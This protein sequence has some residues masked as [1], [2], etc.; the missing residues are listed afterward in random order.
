MDYRKSV[1]A[2]TRGRDA[3]MFK[4]IHDEI[5]RTNGGG[6]GVS[7]E[8]EV[9]GC[10]KFGGFKGRKKVEKKKTRTRTTTKRMM[11]KKKK[12]GKNRGFD[13]G[14]DLVAD[15]DEVVCLVSDS[16]DEKKTGSVQVEGSCSGGKLLSS[17][18]EIVVL[19]G[20]EESKSEPEEIT[21]IVDSE[22]ENNEEEEEDVGSDEDYDEEK[23]DSSFESSGEED[24]ESEKEESQED[25]GEKTEEVKL[26]SKMEDEKLSLDDSEIEVI[27]VE[28]TDVLSGEEE[29]VKA[30]LKRRRSSVTASVSN[31]TRSHCNTKKS[32]KLGAT[33]STSDEEEED[34]D[35]EDSGE[36]VGDDETSGPSLKT[37]K[38]KSG[39]QAHGISRRQ[40]AKK[41]AN[42][43]D[44]DDVVKILGNSLFDEDKVLSE[45]ECDIS[46]G[47]EL[48][49]LWDEMALSLCQ[50][51]AAEEESKVDVSPV[52]E[53][54]TYAL[55]Q[56]G[57]HQ[58]ILNEEIGIICKFCSYVDVEIKYYTAPFGKNPSRYSERRD[59]YGENFDLDDKLHDQDYCDVYDSFTPAQGTVWEIIPGIER[60]LHQHQRDGFEFIWKKVAG[61]IHLNKL[62]EPTDLDGESG[63]IISHA[64]GTG[65]TRLAIVFL[66]SYMKL[67]PNCRPVIIAPCS[68]LLSWEAEFKK[69]KVDIPFHNLNQTRFSGKENAAAMK[70]IKP[71]Q[72]SVNSIRMVKLYSWKKYKSVLGISY[73][74]FEELVGEDTKRS[75]ARNKSNGDVR[76]ALLELPGLLFLDEGHTPRNDQSLIFKALSNVRTDKRI[77]LSG[78]PFQN[79]FDE[80]YNTLL[81]VRPK[82]ADRLT[83]NSASLA[84]KKG[85]EK[86]N[87]AKKTWTSLTSSIVKDG[88]NTLKVEMLDEV[89]RTIDSFVHVH[90]GNIL[91]ERLP[92]LRDSVVVLQPVSL[93]KRLLDK[94]QAEGHPQTFRLEYCLSVT[95]VHPALMPNNSLDEKQILDPDIG[96]KT[97]FLMELI[98]L[99]EA[100]G[101]K[102][103]VFSQ[104]LAPLK[105]IGKQL[106]SRFKWTAGKEVLHM[107]GAVDADQR[108]SLIK[109]FNDRRSDA[110]VLLASTKACSEGI[111]LVGA[112]RVVLLDVVW[113]PS[114]E[115]QAISRAYRL[116]QQKVVYVY[117]LIAS[118][119]TEEDKYCRQARKER[120]SEL[121]FYSSDSAHSSQKISSGISYEK[122]DKL[123]EEIIRRN[124]LKDELKKIIYQPKESFFQDSF[125]LLNLSEQ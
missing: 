100:V 48:D 10:A 114:V 40:P 29:E 117:H 108:Q 120:L 91:Q 109:D 15:S 39:E 50:N 69:W 4:R 57:I 104:Y 122:K 7:V 9:S 79:N 43:L 22:E 102:V 71:G 20:S 55:C 44:D 33:S 95:S 3:Q 76:K 123:L 96:V 23:S 99:S 89:R 113:N 116:G 19:S 38:L 60:D 24:D 21:T 72:L 52:V 111:N 36:R 17:D 65:K 118:E 13:E 97:K 80:L 84:K 75:N 56:Q 105:L 49:K 45:E 11:K 119:T 54:H 59:P 68:M 31:R 124:N 70:L 83:Y 26:E 64:P 46:E 73:K 77:I 27:D 30:G 98:L 35:S 78:T 66:H 51:D 41:R 103:L 28:D 106:E 63:C 32:T 86:I 94:I 53:L 5:K 34:D 58:F 12:G 85:G 1:S 93:Q 14:F 42:A 112:S 62:K 47:E 90:K 18:D 121:V 88:N 8:K 2:R 92:G 25:S 67:Y 6:N 115:R 110:K 125:N 61:G 101:E 37:K 107:H 16:D 82:F 74:L 81:L 87:R